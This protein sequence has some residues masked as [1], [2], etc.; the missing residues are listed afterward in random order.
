MYMCTCI[1]LFNPIVYVFRRLSKVWC[2]SVVPIC[3]R[4]QVS[5]FYPVIRGF[6]LEGIFPHIG[7][8]LALGAPHDQNIFDSDILL[9][10]YLKILRHGSQQI[11]SGHT[12]IS[13]RTLYY[14]HGCNNSSN[15]PPHWQVREAIT[16]R[17]DNQTWNPR[18]S[19]QPNHCIL[20]SNPLVFSYMALG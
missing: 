16:Y 7:T 3:S 17:P 11:V 2:L 20:V 15:T 19:H 5:N 10:K 4:I 6:L 18:Q 12:T 9:L 13:K 8:A 14:V 1:Y